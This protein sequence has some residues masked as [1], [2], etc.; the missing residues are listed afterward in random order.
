MAIGGACTKFVLY[1]NWS[2]AET[3]KKKQYKIKQNKQPKTNHSRNTQVVVR[4][5]KS[6]MSSISSLMS[7]ISSRTIL[8]VAQQSIIRVPCEA[9]R[10]DTS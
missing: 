4:S 1:G 8:L 6:V 9:P 5:H 2:S 10:C 3:K 7:M